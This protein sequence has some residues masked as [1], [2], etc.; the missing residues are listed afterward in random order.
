MRSHSHLTFHL[1]LSGADYPRSSKPSTASL[2]D[3]GIICPDDGQPPCAL[4]CCDSCVGNC[5][6]CIDDP[7]QSLECCPSRDELYGGKDNTSTINFVLNTVQFLVLGILFVLQM[8]ELFRRYQDSIRCVLLPLALCVDRCRGRRH[9]RIAPA[10]A[11]VASEEGRSPLLA[12]VLVGRDPDEMTEEE[13][14]EFAERKK[15]AKDG[16]KDMLKTRHAGGHAG[17]DAAVRDLCG[18]AEERPGRLMWYLCLVVVVYEL[19]VIFG[20]LLELAKGDSSLLCFACDFQE[21]YAEVSAGLPLP[22]SA[23]SETV[24]QVCSQMSHIQYER[25]SRTYPQTGVKIVKEAKEWCV[26]EEMR[27]RRIIAR[28]VNRKEVLGESYLLGWNC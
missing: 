14:K 17:E 25:S 23:R 22:G 28:R 13:K 27:K 3:A 1:H 16:V 15:E 20:F 6:N 2:G 21:Q 12:A 19:A 26:E 4:P 24:R 5:S 7:Y 11:T 10:D 9:G 18:M 8:Q